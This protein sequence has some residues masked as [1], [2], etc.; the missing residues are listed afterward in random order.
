LHKLAS[1]PV[2]MLL[3][4]AA[5]LGLGVAIG[6]LGGRASAPSRPIPAAAPVAAV[7]VPSAAQVAAAPHPPVVVLPND[8]PATETSPHTVLDSEPMPTIAP[9]PVETQTASLVLPPPLPAGVP[10]WQKYALPSPP[11][12]GR[13]MIAVI[14]DDMGVDKK[15][16]ER[17]LQLPGPLTMSFMSYAEALER[18]TD[19]ARAH[20]HEL[21]M[22]VPMEPMGEG[23]DPG[24]GALLNSLPPDE[25][26][27]RV[28][29]DLDKFKG[30]V[31]INNH[32]GSKFT[33]NGPGM[34]VVMEELH[35]RGLL[36]I[37][38]LTTDHS[39]GLDLAHR[40]GV[41]T[42]GRNVFLDNEADAAAVQAQLARTEE[43]ARK[44]GNAIAIG[45]PRDVTIAVLAAW[46]PTLEQKGFVLVPVTAV[47]KARM[48]LST[49]ASH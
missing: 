31:G 6:L 2:G 45:H 14:I 30:Y 48:T 24:P 43:M 25:L 4:A 13:P 44:K 5:I 40:A 22:H 37:D 26:R 39:V 36:F 15:R 41:P 21:M 47:V 17:V 34:Q 8:P 7:A 33:A 38:S 19:E 27:K 16:S 28:V 32:M 12:G 11:A 35:R 49:A 23:I 10:N 42:A 46:L 18:Q 9:P 1:S 20:G 29:D 3:G